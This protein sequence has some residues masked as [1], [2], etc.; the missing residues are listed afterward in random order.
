MPNNVVPL[1][2]E[3]VTILVSLSTFQKYVLKPETLRK[4]SLT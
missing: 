4:S 2:N 1:R 3:F